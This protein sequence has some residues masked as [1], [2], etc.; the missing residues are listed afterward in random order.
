MV[1]P[2]PILLRLAPRLLPAYRDRE[3]GKKANIGNWTGRAA[4]MIVRGGYTV[5]GEL[6]SP[7]RGGTRVS[8]NRG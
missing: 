4:L 5:F 8:H 6:A 3:P 2:G 1:M 7:D